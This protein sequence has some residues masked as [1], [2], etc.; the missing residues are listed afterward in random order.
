MAEQYD[1]G[2]YPATANSIPMSSG[3]VNRL[4]G[5]VGEGA[6]G[7]PD[8]G[9]GGGGQQIPRLDDGANRNIGTVGH[10]NVQQA[11]SALSGSQTQGGS[12]G[13]ASDDF[14]SGLAG[15]QGQ[16]GNQLPDRI[17]ELRRQQVLFITDQLKR[18]RY[19][20]RQYDIRRAHFYRQWLSNR[21]GGKYP[22]N[23]TNRSNLF[24]PYV[25]SNV[26]SIIAKVMEAFFSSLEW[27]EV[28]PNLPD[29]SGQS[30][31]QMQH[32]LMD[33]LHRAKFPEAF[34]LLVRNLLIYGQA[35]IKV[36][37]D[38]GVDVV[39]YK[40]P[41]YAKV[42]ITNPQT[43]Q[44][45]MVPHIDPQTGQ[46][47]EIGYN[48]KVKEVPKN[49]PK[50]LPI[51]TYDLL[52]DP[53]GVYMGM[54]G[55]RTWRDL[56]LEYERHPDHFF[57]EGMDELAGR[58][59]NEEAPDEIVIRIA[60]FWNANDNTWAI[61]TFGEDPEGIS[62]KD[63][64]A[65]FRAA[66]YSPYKRRV[67]GGQPVLLW[68]DVNPFMHQ[69]SPIIQTSFVK[70]PNEIFGLGEPE[71]MGDL[72]EGMNR[73]VNMIMDNWNL[74][75]NK[76]YAYDINA[77]IDHAALNQFNVPGGKVGVSG[78]PQEVIFPLP[79]FT[80]SSGDY[81]ILDIFT[82]M[83]QL[84]SGVADFAG[85]GRGGKGQ[86][87]ATGVQQLMSEQGSRIRMFVRNLELDILQPILEMCASMIQQFIREPFSIS[88][89]LDGMPQMVHPAELV[90]SYQYRIVAANYAM[91][92]VIRQRNL[93]ALANILGQSPYVNQYEAQ[94]ELLKAF[95]IQ[96]IRRI[97]KPP[98][99]VQHEQ[100]MAEEKQL[101]MMLFE[102][103]LK[104][105]KDI[106]SAELKDDMRAMNHRP[107]TKMFEGQIPGEDFTS[108]A[109]RIAQSSG[110]NSMG[111]GGTTEVSAG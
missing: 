22:D 42:P 5:W 61:I 71:I 102:H 39:P 68:Y 47:I 95:E 46:P 55:E 10:T 84:A 103:D 57:K 105:D 98:Q 104:V 40:E 89:Q 29:T 16:A 11:P 58:L 99:Q 41:V 56:R 36:D 52:T 80:P 25:F 79:F 106:K 97:L 96:D 60:E 77:E 92:R 85:P 109:R 63:L 30:A 87:T 14:M 66:S 37:W 17:R 90:G 12:P 33:R 74:G 107:R 76:R 43:G 26:E 83:I 6:P 18:L 86:R 101:Q 78:N 51:D 49:K 34:E 24:V 53:D 28:K 27:F 23:V 108:Q 44:Q 50:F 94:K 82:N 65:S 62:F 59:A 73:T 32:V 75:V 13:M 64:R 4:L 15:Q 20:R 93:M 9:Q 35:G 88:N 31:E 69:R 1:Q 3:G 67:Y 7:T 70:I 54:L 111:L 81:Q 100:Q 38:W 91:N 45:E 2:G 48:L 72:N 19:F 21:D 110:A 8:M